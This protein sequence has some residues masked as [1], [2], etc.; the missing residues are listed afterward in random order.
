MLRPHA[1][2]VVLLLLLGLLLAACTDDESGGPVGTAT[3]DADQTP[4]VA[5]AAAAPTGVVLEGV[6][7]EYQPVYQELRTR[8]E[9]ARD[10]FADRPAPEGTP[11]LTLELLTANGNRGEDLLQPANLDATRVFLDRFK[12]L[13]AAGVTVQIVYP[14]FDGG[15]PRHD[16]Y[17]EFYRAVVQEVRQRGLL[18]LIETSAPFA[19]TEFSSL[20]IDYSGKTPEAYL[21]ERLDQARAI[22]HELQPDYLSLAEEEQTE[23]M[24]TG[25]DISDDAYLEFL[26]SAP[27]AIDPPPGVKLGAGS[28]SWESTEF[29][30]GIIADTPLDYVDIHVYPLS[31]GFTDYLEVAAEW[32]SSARAAGKEAVIGESWLYKVSVEE[33]QG[34]AEFQE[35]FGRDAY[36]FW[37]P[38]DVLFMQTAVELGRVSGVRLLSYF[39]SNY[40][41]AYVDYDQV[42]PG[43]SQ[44][45][46]RQT[47]N[48]ATWRAVTAGELSATGEEFRRLA[49]EFA[50]GE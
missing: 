37:E 1:R 50:E 47:S 46:V 19:G 14:L 20:R 42:S 18:L 40:L 24:L 3:L 21:Q 39:W 27:V 48:A 4:A 26:R 12:K 16:E 6:P 41:F 15:F 43:M 25:L 11:A 5:G 28:G 49:S 35:V 2:D 33:L 29:I 32:A 23:R 38:L 22:A 10:G 8:L 45:E 44:P 13:G 9:A 34:G 17:V 7:A 36:S 31:N 30:Q